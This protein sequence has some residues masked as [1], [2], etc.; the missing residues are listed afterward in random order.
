[1]TIRHTLTLAGLLAIGAG[2]CNLSH[3]MQDD[4]GPPPGSDAG[5]G[6][7]CEAV[8]TPPPPCSGGDPAFAAPGGGW[9]PS[10]AECTYR[11]S[12]FTGGGYEL[13]VDAHGCDRWEPVGP[14]GCAIDAGMPLP[15]DCDG[16]AEAQCI[17]TAGC[18]PTY[19]DA[20]CSSCEP[21][22][23]CADCVDWEFW[24]CR[25]FADACEAAFCSTASPWGCGMGEP[26]CSSASPTGLGSCSIPGCVPA[27]AAEGFME[28]VDRCV[29]VTASSCTVAC[30]AVMPSCP[31]GTTAEADGFCWTGRCIPSEVCGR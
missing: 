16:L 7:C 4:G 26:D 6:V 25:P 5:G 9:A 24:T 13:R 21:G 10:F 2:G 19:H 12:G 1:M 11:L 3:S 22:A 15:S 14:A 28:P 27:V 29:A 20:C 18:V 31:D 23:G 8:L 17:T 30:R